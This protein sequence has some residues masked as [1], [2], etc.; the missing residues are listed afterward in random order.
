VP[1]GIGSATITA[2]RK[3]TPSVAIRGCEFLGC[4]NVV[5]AAPLLQQVSEEVCAQLSPNES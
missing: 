2:C 1:A 5:G 3:L 4:G